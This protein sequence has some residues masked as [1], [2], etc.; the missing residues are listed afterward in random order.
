MYIKIKM[1]K[2]RDTN[3]SMSLILKKVSV[4]IIQINVIIKLSK[5]Y[6]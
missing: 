1:Q 3:D 2:N 5:T 4:R 6:L